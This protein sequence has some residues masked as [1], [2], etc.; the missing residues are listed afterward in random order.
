MDGLR[1]IAVLAVVGYHLGI[2]WL[3]GGWL[4]VDIFFVLSGFLITSLLLHERAAWGR[5]DLVGFWLAR[6]RR[7][8]PTLTLMLLAVTAV[9]AVWAPPSRRAADAWDVLSAFCYVANWRL[10]LSNDQYFSSL[11]MP[12]PVVHTWS[13]AIEEQFYLIFPILLIALLTLAARS[14]RRRALVAGALTVLAALSVWRMAALYVPGADPSRVYYG[15]DTRAFELLIGAAVAVLVSGREFGDRAGR[16][17]KRAGSSPFGRTADA[18][19][20]CCRVASIPALI[21]LLAGFVVLTDTSAIPFRGGLAALCVVA[22]API[23]TG[24]SLTRSPVQRVLASKPLRRVGLLSYALYVWHWPVIVFLNDRRIHLPAFARGVAELA[25]SV[26][27]AYLTYR[28]VERPVRAGGL[29]ALVPG[30][31]GLGRPVAVGVLCALTAGLVVLPRSEVGAAA[32]TGDG[33]QV[34]A[35][36]YTPMATRKTVTLIGNSV[37]DSL[38]SAFPGVKYPDLNVATD[39]SLGCDPFPGQKVLDGQVQPIGAGCPAFHRQ[40]QERLRSDPPDLAIF[41]VPQSITSDMLVNGRT[42]HFG[43]PAYLDW[44]GSMLGSVR[45]ESLAA[46]AKHFAVA[47]LTCHRVIGFTDDA[48]HINDDGRVATIDAKVRQWAA[49]TGTTVFDFDK[50]LCTGG[51]HDAINGTALYADGYHYT[52]ASGSVIWSWLAPLIQQ[53]FRRDG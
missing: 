2:P 14:R 1:G 20:R 46:G 29:R 38:Q 49:S 53:V 39:V 33:V 34:R 32:A 5:I 19:D 37:P 31:P 10:L 27:L 21:V 35:T 41:M 15:T 50:L 16:T 9:A 52:A 7:L 45:R 6:A 18:I 36:P 51:Y 48:K 30:R 11:S 43:T 28:Y 4:G 26:A 8:L 17:G 23:V 44:L 13:L 40:W 47:T 22:V 25:V 42:L 3:R 12:S 24:A